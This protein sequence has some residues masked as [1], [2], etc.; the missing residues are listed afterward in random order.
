MEISQKYTDAMI[1]ELA[2][3]GGFEIEK[4]FYNAE[5]F[6]IYSLWWPI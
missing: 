1:D 4:E 6:Y 3:D 5:Y 2:G